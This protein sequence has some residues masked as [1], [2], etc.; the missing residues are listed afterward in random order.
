MIDTVIF[1]LDG[2]LLNTLDDLKDSTNFALRN[3]GCPERSLE[4]VRCFVGN[5]VK[6]LIERAIPN[7]AENPDFENCL[8]M[9]KENY[10]LNM[11]NKTAPYDGVIE[12][13]QVLKRY[14]FKTAVV[15]NKFDMAVKH[16]CKTYFDGL[17]QAAIGEADNVHRK[18]AP[19]GVFKAM[20]LLKSGPETSI[21]CGDSDVD[22]LTAKNSGIKCIG[23]TWG[24]R[25]RE[26]LQQEGADYIVD[27]PYEIAE[28]LS[29]GI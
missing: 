14:G 5:G 25:S 12:L 18:P 28:L 23:V 27:A 26:L 17:V 13:L 9:F 8:R 7:G 21:Y 19:D 15:S 1:D 2:T 10:A 16:L 22:V 20:E 4:E 6:K 24:F 3:F 29:A 11:Y